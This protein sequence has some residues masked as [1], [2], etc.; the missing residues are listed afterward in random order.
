MTFRELLV[1]NKNSICAR[2]MDVVIQTYPPETGKFL[3]SAKDEFANPVGSTLR[4][5]LEALFGQLVQGKTPDQKAAEFLERIIQVRAIQ[6]FT[7]AQALGFVFEIK[8]IIREAVGDEID[9]H[10]L[11][12]DMARLEAAVDMMM[13][14]A[15]ET[16]VS[17]RE[18]V[19]KA[20]SE[21]M[22]ALFAQAIK[23]SD[24]FCEIPEQEQPDIKI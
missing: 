18:K 8:P 4:Q 17:C 10:S 14:M 6:D 3:R 23:R 13:L 2:W 20:R 12:T 1:H 9:K 19:Y 21:E 11:H 15:V 5:G 7:P 16:Y 24:L 22:R